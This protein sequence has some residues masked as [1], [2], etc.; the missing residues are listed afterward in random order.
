V[1]GALIHLATVLIFSGQLVVSGPTQAPPRDRV[2]PPRVGT[3]V[4]KGRVVDGT[5]GAAIARAR[6]M[7][8]G[9]G[10]GA[11]ALTDADGGFTFTGLP[12]GP[13]MVMVQKSTYLPAR[14]PAAGRTI[15]S[16]IR[17]T[18]LRDGQVL[19]NIVV[20]MF[21][22][23]SITGRVFDANGDPVDY[24][25][26]TLL[27]MPAGG[28]AGKP[29]MREGTQ[30]NDLGEFRL[31]RLEAGTYL[32]QVNARRM[33]EMAFSSSSP[34]APQA[35]PAAQPLPTF[36]S[37]ALAIEQAQPIIVDR[38][39]SVSGI[40]VVLA[41]GI[42]GIVTGIVTLADGQPLPANTYPSVMVRRVVSDVSQNWDYSSS[43]ATT[44]PDG[45]FRAVLA[46]GDYMIEARV[47]PRMGGPTRQED[48]QLATAR[49][50]VVSGGEESLT[51]AVGPGASATGRVVFEGTTPPPSSPGRTRI[52]MFSNSGM[53]RS[54]E[55][56]VAP[57]WSFR[58]TGLTGTCSAD[59]RGTFGRW[60]LKSIIVHGEN[61]VD[62]PVTFQPG[63]QLR[64]VQVIV[65]DKQSSMVF[66][67]ADEN[68]QTTREYVVVAYPVDKE[69]W[70]N[71]ART[72]MPPIFTNP[73]AMRAPMNQ[74]GPAA[75][76]A[77]RPQ[78]LSGL[79]SGDYYVI[80]VDDM[81]PEDFRDPVVLDRLRSSATRVTLPEG[82]TIEV[83]LRR[84]NFAEVTRQK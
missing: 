72:Y 9:V 70:T 74:P 24:A 12:P 66:Q 42:P 69:R 23:G 44:R 64:N 47:N 80:A 62:S 40:D 21:H 32:V 7:M 49:V 31:G 54:G 35:P 73:D 78:M 33:D 53:C 41:E 30:T 52:P 63:Q 26:V 76:A 8:Q 38:A 81:E 45:T 19:D 39:Q 17:P 10:G 37:S 6:V 51:L 4:V 14:Y 55:A 18:I 3:A 77:A 43:G 58:I 29:V 46:P 1:E 84:V 20:P 16:Q 75:A 25:Q 5:T 27:R 50:S 56:E 22:G 79:R 67:V 61:V 28:R 13:V 15:R 36:Y 65:S 34:L 71:G 60:M 59:P 82:A 2:P 83:P 68:G 48:E 11:P 57:D